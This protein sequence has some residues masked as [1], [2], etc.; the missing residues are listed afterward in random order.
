MKHSSSQIEINNNGNPSQ[1]TPK[2]STTQNCKRKTCLKSSNDKY[3]TDLT[4][5]CRNANKNHHTCKEI[6]NKGICSR[7]QVCDQYLKPN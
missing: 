6:L 1:R 4:E 7:L 3:K 2:S 5:A